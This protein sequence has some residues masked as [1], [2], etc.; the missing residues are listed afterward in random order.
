MTTTITAS[1][2]SKKGQ[3]VDT[4][5]VDQLIRNYKK[6]RWV[7]NTQRMGK[8]DS[9]SIWYGIEELQSFLQIA[10]ENQA[11]G[12]KMYFGVYP[13]NFAKVP[14]FQGRQTVILVATKA[15]VTENG[16]VNKDIY[17]NKEGRSDI[18]AFNFG[19]L[20]P[21]FCNP[22]L[23]QDSNKNFGMDLAKIGISIIEQSDKVIII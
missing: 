18:L 7:Q 17:L 15:K 5:H 1:K 11:D 12:I 3:L 2:A 9:L 20:C 22:Y 10:R 23:M 19:N 13:D 8:V 4:H 6:E 14:E 16:T 21:P